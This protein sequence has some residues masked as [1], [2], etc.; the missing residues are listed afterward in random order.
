MFLLASV[1]VLPRRMKMEYDGPEDLPF[2]GK[3]IIRSEGI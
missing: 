3:N 2:G 1:V